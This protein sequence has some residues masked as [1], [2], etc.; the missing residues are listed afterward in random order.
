MNPIEALLSEANRLFE[1]DA[2]YFPAGGGEP[3]PLRV[4]RERTD[5]ARFLDAG[6]PQSFR[7]V[8]FSFSRADLRDADGEPIIPRRGD[9]LRAKDG[10]YRLIELSGVAYLA[11]FDAGFDGRLLTYWERE[12]AAP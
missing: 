9:R 6:A 2:V 12:G 11:R 8:G 5:T 1:E 7:Q 3:V 10:I 4:T